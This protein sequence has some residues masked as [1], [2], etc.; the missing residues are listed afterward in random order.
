[1]IFLSCGGPARALAQTRGA[2]NKYNVFWNTNTPGPYQVEVV[3]RGKF[4]ATATVHVSA[5]IPLSIFL[6]IFEATSPK[7]CRVEGPEGGVVGQVYKCRTVIVDELGVPL[8]FSMGD[9]LNA[10]ILA[11]QNSFKNLKSVD[12]GDGTFTTSL[13]LLQKGKFEFHMKVNDQDIGSGPWK[14]SA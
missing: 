3:V 2:A 14:F 9:N 12:N 1:M 11:V 7:N 4:K 10:Q 6:L 8:P 5:G 13:E